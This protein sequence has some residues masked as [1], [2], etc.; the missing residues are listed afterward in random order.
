MRTL[1]EG[2]LRI[3]LPETASGRNFDSPAHGLSHCMKA[4]DWIIDLPDRVYFIEI[5]DPDAQGATAHPERDRHIED[6]RAGRL[7]DA[8]IGKFRDSFLYEWACGR[9]DKPISYFVVIACSALDDALLLGR[10]DG[11][12]R[13][14]PAGL[15]PNWRRA[16]AQDC[17]VFNVEKWN[18]AFPQFP[19][20][21]V[22]S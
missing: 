22:Q 5:K 15:H 14:L 9:D 17:L 7:D 1:R 2:E 19:L 11:L 6:L 8:L 18:R 13:R 16:I 4:V 10:T 21:R 3:T 12:K 20:E